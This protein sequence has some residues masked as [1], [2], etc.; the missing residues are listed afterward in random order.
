AGAVCKSCG[1]IIIFAADGKFCPTCRTTVHNSCAPELLCSGCGRP[2]QPHESSRM[3]SDSD[4]VLPRALRAPRSAGPT[5]ALFVLL[6]VIFV[7][8]LLYV[9]FETGAI[10]R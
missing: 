5:V 2:Y 8:I 7:V 10:S 1:K 6:G 4:L 9:L 3:R